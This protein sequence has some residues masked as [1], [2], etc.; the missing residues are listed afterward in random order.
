M[1]TFLGK[2]EDVELGLWSKLLACLGTFSLGGIFSKVVLSPTQKGFLTSLSLEHLMS[3]TSTR[4]RRERP[5]AYINHSH[6]CK[7][8]RRG[9]IPVFQYFT[10][11]WAGNS[12]ISG[13]HVTPQSIFHFSHLI[14]LSLAKNILQTQTTQIN[15][16]FYLFLWCWWYVNVYTHQLH[17]VTLV[18]SFKRGSLWETRKLYN[19]SLRLCKVQSC[20]CG[21]SCNL[22]EYPNTCSV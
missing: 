21:N 3:V 6:P 1:N 5:G 15:P 12:L 9:K 10:S 19:K 14:L 7:F 22:A 16:C 18:A 2:L 13:P 17:I 8:S 4:V 11:L 20:C